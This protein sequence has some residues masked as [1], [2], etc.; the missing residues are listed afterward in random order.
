MK[1]DKKKNL[2]NKPKKNKKLIIFAGI[3]ILLSIIIIVIVNLNNK[4]EKNNNSFIYYNAVLTDNTVLDAVEEVSMTLDELE[5]NMKIIQENAKKFIENQN[6]KVGKK[7]TEVENDII[8]DFKKK[9]I[10]EENDYDKVYVLEDEDLKKLNT[11]FINAD[12]TYYLINYETFDV[13]NTKAI[14]GKY[15]LSEIEPVVEEKEEEKKEEK[16]EE[17]I[18]S[19]YYIKVNYQANV[20]TVYSNNDGNLTPIRAMICST[21]EYTPPCGKYPNT[22]YKLPGN[23]WEWGALQGNVYGH[24]VTKIVGNILFHS[25]PYTASNP[26]ALEYWEYDKLG[27]SASAGCVRLRIEDSKWIYDNMPAGTV[28]EFYADSNPGPLGKPGVQKISDNEQCRNWDPTDPHPE[29]PWKKQKENENKK[30]EENI[31]NNSTEKK[32]SEN[33]IEKKVKEEKNNTVENLVNNTIVNDT[34][35]TKNN[36][37]ITNDTVVNNIVEN[38]NVIEN[39][40]KIENNIINNSINENTNVV[41]NNNTPSKRNITNEID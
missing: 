33:L 36:N 12:G 17:K 15:K 40:I 30:Q 35:N 7:I 37:T 3:L 4:K 25:V 34:T 18:T 8:N 29:N 26:G 28:V 24:Y 27:T 9:R 13:I 20:V 23:R 31:V 32:S 6:E 19:S 16:K 5:Y 38:N 21:G 11:K 22:V 39:K 1:T 14:D 10:I 41:E 2:K